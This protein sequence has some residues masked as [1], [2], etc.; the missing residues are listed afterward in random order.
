[1]TASIFKFLF[2]SSLLHA[3]AME[4]PATVPSLDLKRY[5]GVWHEIAR[6]PNPFQKGCDSATARYT[7]LPDGTLEVL[8]TCQNQDG[9]WRSVL[10][11]ARVVDTVTGA[12]LKVS[13]VPAWLRWTGIGWGDYWVV[14][15]APDYTYAVVSEPRRRYLWILSRT[16]TLP[17]EVYAGILQRLRTMK[18]DVTLLI[19]SRPGAVEP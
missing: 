12:K 17:R 15:L 5:L 8:N 3:T 11:T 7:L 19:D 16:P 4:P 13:F 10:G 2:I 6:Y 9:S 14:D 18:F 1:M